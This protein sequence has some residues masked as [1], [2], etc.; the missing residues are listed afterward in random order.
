MSF[1]RLEPD[2]SHQDTVTVKRMPTG[3]MKAIAVMPTLK[4]GPRNADALVCLV[5]LVEAIKKCTGMLRCQAAPQKI[6]HLERLE[7]LRT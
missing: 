6:L 3:Q 4:I 7:Y 1:D 5:G 2:H